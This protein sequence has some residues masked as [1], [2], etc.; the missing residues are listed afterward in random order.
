MHMLRIILG[1][2]INRF[3]GQVVFI[4]GGANGIGFAAAK[5]FLSENAKVIICSRTKKNVENAVERLRK[6]GK[7]IY[8]EIG[9]LSCNQVVVEMFER[10]KDKLGG[11]DILVN[12]A[13]I[14]KPVKVEDI[15]IDEWRYIIDNNLTNSFLT[16]KHV[17]KY[18]KEK[19]YGKIINVSSIAGRFRSKLAGVHYSCAKSAIIT[20]TRQ[21]A[22]EYGRY[23]INVNAIC[24]GQT[25]TEM[26][27]PFLVGNAENVIK[28]SIPLGYIASAEQQAD[29]ILFLASDQ[30]NY[31][32]GAI[33]DV[34][35]GQL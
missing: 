9:D 8:G 33:V 1:N 20:L 27:E 23:G 32:T 3:E 16:C 6:V 2:N 24:P 21:L 34:N 30:S 10:V 12:S 4:S 17:L 7:G 15:S 13:G 5:G 18:M 14:S 26:L 31:M 35:G 28:D 25:K 11:I 19:K 22:A 29:V